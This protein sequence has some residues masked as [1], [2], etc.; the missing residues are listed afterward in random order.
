M[1]R[2]Y[3]KYIRHLAFPYSPSLANLPAIPVA[4]IIRR[5]RQLQYTIIVHCICASYVVK[6]GHLT[7]LSIL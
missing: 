5:L 3:L 2:Q 1:N 4:A 6:R 7:W